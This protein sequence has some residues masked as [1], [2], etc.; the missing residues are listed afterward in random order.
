MR[1]RRNLQV[2]RCKGLSWEA[3]DGLGVKPAGSENPEGLEQKEDEDAMVI[4]D[5]SEG[6]D[7]EPLLK[8]I[9]T[10]PVKAEDD[11]AE[12]ASKAH[13]DEA[14]SP[15][16]KR[17][18]QQEAGQGDASEQAEGAD[19]KAAAE[20]AKSPRVRLQKGKVAGKE[21]TPDKAAG[22]QGKAANPNIFQRKRAKGA[23]A[24]G[25][26]PAADGGKTRSREAT[27]VEPNQAAGKPAAAAETI[28][29][30]ANEAAAEEAAGKPAA[31]KGRQTKDR[32]ATAAA[33]EQAADEPTATEAK[34]STAASEQAPAPASK[35]DPPATSS[36]ARSQ[37]EPVQESSGRP[38]QK[39][40]A[41][42]RA[43]SGQPAPPKAGPMS[44]LERITEGLLKAVESHDKL[45]VD[46][47]KLDIQVSMQRLASSDG[48]L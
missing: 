41:Q 23:A 43:G 10:E 17:K 48:P 36:A 33:L 21:G 1:G 37:K 20:E 7:A 32:E 13:A 27:P 12:A 2:G 9:K 35:E 39:Q 4:L 31:V 26:A 14:K 19:A 38:A 22:G 42:Q 25:K 28:Q 11:R 44:E 16:G 40:P 8:L 46:L 29:T 18:R 30:A 3:I 34:Q 24:A 45:M 47:K 5:G 15:K 6:S